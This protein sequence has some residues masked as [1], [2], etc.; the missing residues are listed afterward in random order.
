MP[1]AIRPG[2]FRKRIA[3]I[4]PDPAK[5]PSWF[6]RQAGLARTD[7]RRTPEYP[8]EL[9]DGTGSYGVLIARIPPDAFLWLV[10]KYKDSDPNEY[11][12]AGLV[13]LLRRTGIPVR[14]E[15]RREPIVT[16]F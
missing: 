13:A 5:W 11:D 8:Y 15:R 12:V 7:P 1:K 4:D 9:V 3:K 2:L 10:E 6:R 16:R 14:R